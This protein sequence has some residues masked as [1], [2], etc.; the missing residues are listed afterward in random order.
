MGNGYRSSSASVFE[1]FAAVKPAAAQRLPLKNSV[2]KA[3]LFSGASEGRVPRV[4]VF[5]KKLRDGRRSLTDGVRPSNVSV[6]GSEPRPS[7]DHEEILGNRLP[8]VPFFLTLST[9]PENIL[10][11][12][13]LE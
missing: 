3:K 13:R 8:G 1:I 6:E 2:W 11:V 7:P 4:R 10:L 9:N 5:N 12:A